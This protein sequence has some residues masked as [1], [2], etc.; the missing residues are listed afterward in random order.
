MAQNKCPER[1]LGGVEE[2]VQP[3]ISKLYGS[4]GPPPTGDEESADKDEL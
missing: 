4:A 1:G 3:I 2:I